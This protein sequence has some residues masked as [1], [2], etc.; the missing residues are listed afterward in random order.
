MCNASLL[1][2]LSIALKGREPTGRSR[3]SLNEGKL[4]EEDL[5]GQATPQSDQEYNEDASPCLE[6][7][8]CSLESCDQEPAGACQIATLKHQQTRLTG[9]LRSLIK[10]GSFSSLLGT[11]AYSPASGSTSTSAIASASLSMSWAM[12]TVAPAAALHT[13]VT[14]IVQNA[15]SWTHT[16]ASAGS[17]NGRLLTTFLPRF[18]VP[19]GMGS[20]LS[21]RSHH[22]SMYA[23][24]KRAYQSPSLLESA[25]VFTQ[26]CACFAL[27]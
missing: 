9:C 2:R 20:S 18:Q 10:W 24:L 1:V 26:R 27:L 14:P 11:I 8:R 21:W 3:K 19:P 6:S 4:Y 17:A 23:M 13:F 12:S 5:K 25:C 7:Y 22:L 15:F 16:P